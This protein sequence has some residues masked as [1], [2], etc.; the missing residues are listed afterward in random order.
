MR[1]WSVMLGKIEVEA[2]IGVG[3]GVE[4]EVIFIIQIGIGVWESRIMGGDME[5]DVKM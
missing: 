1:L 3:I 4:V 5:G 2:G